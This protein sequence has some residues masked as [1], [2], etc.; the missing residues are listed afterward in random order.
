MKH[1]TESGETTVLNT[2]SLCLFKPSLHAS[3]HHLTHTAE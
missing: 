2:S 1:V 3:D